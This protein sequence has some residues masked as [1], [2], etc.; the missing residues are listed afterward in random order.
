ME[1]LYGLW[2]P[3]VPL[4]LVAH[5][6]S[7]TPLLAPPLCHTFISPLW[8]YKEQLCLQMKEPF[9]AVGR[10]TSAHLQRHPQGFI[11]TVSCL[12]SRHFQYK[13]S[14]GKCSHTFSQAHTEMQ[15]KNAFDRC[16]VRPWIRVRPQAHNFHL[17]SFIQ[18]REGFT[19]EQQM[20]EDRK[21]G[22]QK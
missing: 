16:C 6:T 19:A 5:I 18:D 22:Q 9:I 20:Q 17:F 13:H 10:R 1:P 8:V 14:K 3:R 21:S 4:L 12:L 7:L 2:P 11:F 15:R